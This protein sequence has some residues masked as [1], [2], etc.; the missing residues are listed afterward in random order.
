MGTGRLLDSFLII[1]VE[2][3]FG[4]VAMGRKIGSRGI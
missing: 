1:K 2:A 3:L 4:T